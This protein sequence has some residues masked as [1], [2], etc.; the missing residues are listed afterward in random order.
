VS[1]DTH[2]CTASHELRSEQFLLIAKPILIED[3][4]WIAAEC[5]IG[6]GVVIGEGAVLGARGAAFSDLKPWT[7]Y[8]GNPAVAIKER[9]HQG[10]APTR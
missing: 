6:P 8:R 4:A 9:R 5:F 1:Q 7:I 10:D 3:R 2:I